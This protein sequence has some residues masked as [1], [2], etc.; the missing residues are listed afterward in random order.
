MP[1]SPA[2]PLSP[3][4]QGDY[5]ALLRPLFMLSFLVDDFLAENEF[6]GAK[7]VLLSSRLQQDRVR[8]CAS[9]CTQ[10][11][12]HQGD[13]ADLGVECRPS[14]NRSAATTRS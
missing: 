11:K 8:A 5:Q 13:R 2:I 12:R 10:R 14:S 1:A 7:S 4:K 6:F 9:R 3:G